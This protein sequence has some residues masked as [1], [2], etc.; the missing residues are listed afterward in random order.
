MLLPYFEKLAS[1]G[2][3]HV[4]GESVWMAA[5]VQAIHLLFLAF[6]A[7]AIL[8]VD[9]RLMGRGL[10]EQ[11]VAQVARSARPWLLLGFWGLVVTGIPQLM[12]Y[13]MKEYY[14]V[15][16]WIKTDF[17]IA[18]VI[19]TFTVRK[20]VTMADPVRVGPFWAKVVG[21][22]SILLWAGVAIPARLIGL[23]S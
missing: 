1:F 12:A 22:V 21:L 16:F 8:I 11:P 6:F 3:S 23:L 5:M 15:Y 7:G 2:F 9:L 18:A 13:A 17:F 4:M 20:R 10:R 19:F 14:S